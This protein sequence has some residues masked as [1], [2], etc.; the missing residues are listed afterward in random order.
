MSIAVVAVVVVVEQ[1]IVNNSRLN[2][3]EHYETSYRLRMV[4]A[5]VHYH[6][7][8]GGLYFCQ[9]K[10]SFGSAQDSVRIYGTRCIRKKGS[11]LKGVG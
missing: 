10:N 7:T 5:I 8:D 2:I 11:N 4:L 3:Y 1:M 6:K 9:A